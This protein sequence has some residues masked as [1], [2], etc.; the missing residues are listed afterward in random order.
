MA[1]GTIIVGGIWLACCGVLLFLEYMREHGPKMYESSK[2]RVGK[3][4]KSSKQTAAGATNQNNEPQ[5]GGVETERQT[6]AESRMGTE[7][8]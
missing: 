1:C 6:E 2:V 5:M 8:V 4:W 3:Y 7:T